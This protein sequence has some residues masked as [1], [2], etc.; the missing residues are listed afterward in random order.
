MDP[1]TEFSIRPRNG[2]P[3]N[4]P[5]FTVQA[6]IV[7][8]AKA[9]P[10]SPACPA[11]TVR[12]QVKARAIE[13]YRAGEK[14]AAIA[15]AAGVSPAVV[16]SW[17]HHVGVPRRVR[18]GGGIFTRLRKARTSGIFLMPEDIEFLLASGGDDD[19]NH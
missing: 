10:C 12:G 13:A 15:R 18:K 11:A 6:E 3:G 14:V 16:S 17:A 2:D 4:L 5:R 9:A 19:A 1:M 8:P 7:P